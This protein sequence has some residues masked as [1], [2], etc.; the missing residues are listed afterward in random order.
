[1]NDCKNRVRVRACVRAHV[2]VC[3]LVLVHLDV[4]LWQ[5]CEPKHRLQ[6]PAARATGYL[7]S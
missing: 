5:V 6:S 4:I 2:F 1:M 3:V 7:M